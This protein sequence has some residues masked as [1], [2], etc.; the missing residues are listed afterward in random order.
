MIENA[1]VERPFLHLF[2]DALQFMLLSEQ[3]EGSDVEGLFARSSIIHSVFALES[4][5]NCCLRE[6]PYPPRLLEKCDALALLEKFEFVLATVQN[7]KGLDRG[8]RI[9]QSVNEL[10]AI[11]NRYV[12]PKA[13]SGPLIEEAFDEN[14]VAIA[15]SEHPV[16][17]LWDRPVC[18][19]AG[20][21]RIVIKAVID[22]LDNFF[23]DL[24]RF[25][26]EH[27][28]RLL[29][30]SAKFN[31]KHMGDG[32]GQGFGL[33]C[34]MRVAGLLRRARLGTRFIDFDRWVWDD[35]HGRPAASIKKPA[36]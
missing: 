7:G 13:K 31:T 34:D 17:G 9:V 14:I 4:A 27:V 19:R 3:D 33:M 28:E 12:H 16:T 26:T 35:L 36:I 1:V 15:G 8:G 11:R 22:F 5:A 21:A 32:E 29:V 30:S 6:H 18:W 23:V 20:D 10:I 24:C 2:G 25:R